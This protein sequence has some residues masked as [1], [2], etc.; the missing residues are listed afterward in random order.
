MG[1][2]IHGKGQAQTWQGRWQ[3]EMGG[4]ES[5]SKHRYGGIK[6]RQKVAEVRHRHGSGGKW[7]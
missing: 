6:V 3:G 1:W 5:G 2:G 4:S 7:Q